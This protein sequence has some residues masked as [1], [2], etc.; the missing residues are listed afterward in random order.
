MTKKDAVPIGA[1][2]FVGIRYFQLNF[3]EF[4]F[5]LLK[6]KEKQLNLG[7]FFYV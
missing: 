6:K 4:K 2:S 3:I 1:M 7:C 5:R